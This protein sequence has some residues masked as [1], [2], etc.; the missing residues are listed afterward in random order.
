[1]NVARIGLLLAGFPVQVPGVTINRFC[2][3]A[4]RRWADKGGAI[5]WRG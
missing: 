2:A 1:M 4:C 5:R 3:S